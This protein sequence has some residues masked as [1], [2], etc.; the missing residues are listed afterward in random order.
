MAEAV[1]AAQ[2]IE[3]L[4]GSRTLRRRVKSFEGLR[5]EVRQG[6]SYA[7][8]ESVAQRFGLTAAEIAA[9]VAVPQ[10]TLARR[11]V[12]HKL[13]AAESDRLLRF[14]RIAALAEDVLGSREKVSRWL[15]APNRAL[16][17]QPPLRHLDTDLGSRQVESVLLRIAHGVY[18]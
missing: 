3:T 9:V 7:V 8:V 18:S 1:T 13:K 16:G 11:K 12:E 17:N 4:G 15:H 6:L 10:R 14:G 2:V 5:D